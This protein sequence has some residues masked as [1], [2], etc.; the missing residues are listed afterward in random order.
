VHLVGHSLGGLVARWYVQ[1][2]GGHARVA[3]TISMATPFGGT[4]LA[5]LRVLVGN[6][7][8]AA[9]SVLGRLKERA[10]EHGVPH[11]SIVAAK[12]RVVFPPANA[13]FHHGDVVT[14]AGRGHNTLL[15]DTEAIDV[16]VRRV[17]EAHLL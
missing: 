8:H 13:A 11:V 9:S 5:R 17:K 16:V 15:F 3:Q 2:L 14:L 1:E 6:D 7:L 10:H 12:D 4:P